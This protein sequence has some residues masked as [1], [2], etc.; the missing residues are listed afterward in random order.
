[1]I[2]V[3]AATMTRPLWGEERWGVLWPAKACGGDAARARSYRRPVH[4]KPGIDRDREY[5]NQGYHHGEHRLAWHTHT[6]FARGL[7]LQQ[8]SA[9]SIA[10]S[11]ANGCV[12]LRQARRLHE[13]RKSLDGSAL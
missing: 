11:V 12:R 2:I 10:F 3:L 7:S 1:M 9:P 5:A 4:V 6:S 13:D 8:K